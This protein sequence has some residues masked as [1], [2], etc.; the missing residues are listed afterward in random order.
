MRQCRRFFPNVAKVSYCLLAVAGGVIGGFL[1]SALY[2]SASVAADEQP[3]PV[4]TTA[5]ELVDRSGKRVGYW[6][7][8][9]DGTA[10][11]FFDRG[12]KKR[13][14]FGLSESGRPLVCLNDPDGSTLLALDLSAT[15]RPR[16]LMSDP[17]FEGRVFLGVNEPDSPAP[18]AETDAWVLQFRGKDSRPF[19]TIGMRAGRGGG[20]ALRD[21]DGQEWRAPLLSGTR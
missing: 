20:V 11:S 13:A 6:G 7:P 3:R 16:L 12:G 17:D 15:G 18:K 21:K 4:R 5:I 9:G 19:A 8:R 14:E 2:P 1:H 10:L